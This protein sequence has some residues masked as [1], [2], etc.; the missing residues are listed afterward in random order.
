MMLTMLGCWQ[1]GCLG[2]EL[3]ASSPTKLWGRT[4]VVLAGY[5]CPTPGLT[6]G[7]PARERG[8]QARGLSTDYRQ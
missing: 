6:T 2:R 7:Q 8:N 3:L 1:S 5:L 4:S